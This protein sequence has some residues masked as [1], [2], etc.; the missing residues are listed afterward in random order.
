VFRYD[1]WKVYLSFGLRTPREGVLTIDSTL[2]SS[3]TGIQASAVISPSRNLTLSRKTS[4][5]TAARPVSGSFLLLYAIKSILYISPPIASP[6]FSLY[7][8][9]T[10]S[11]NLFMS[12]PSGHSK[13]H[14][15]PT[16]NVFPSAA[17]GLV[18]PPGRS[19]AATITAT[20]MTLDKTSN[21][22]PFILFP[23]KI[24]DLP[25]NRC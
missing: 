9:T 14:S 5:S 16:F 8:G 11:S 2:F 20:N 13:L 25:V 21:F 3:V 10:A 17:A 18:Q 4:L 15:R 1:P 7:A 23:P 22:L 19:V 12:S 6:P 24:L